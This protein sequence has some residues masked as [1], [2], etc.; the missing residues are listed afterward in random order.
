MQ[1]TKAT[2]ELLT[3]GKNETVGGGETVPD[4]LGKSNKYAL[5]IRKNILVS[6]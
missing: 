3:A 4:N 1:C 5:N 2:E 6:L